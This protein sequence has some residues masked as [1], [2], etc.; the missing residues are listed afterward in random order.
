MDF[1]DFDLD[2][3]ETWLEVLEKCSFRLAKFMNPDSF[4]LVFKGFLEVLASKLFLFKELNPSQNFVIR[5]SNLFEKFK[6]YEDLSFVQ[7]GISSE[8]KQKSVK[9][10]EIRKKLDSYD[11]KKYIKEE[12]NLLLQFLFK[13]NEENLPL[14]M[15]TIHNIIKYISLYTIHKPKPEIF[16]ALIKFLGFCISDSKKIKEKKRSLGEIIKK[17][18][19]KIGIINII[20][21]ILCEK[22]INLQIFSVLI[23]FSYKLLKNG[24]KM[25]QKDFFIY[26]YSVPAS[27]NLFERIHQIILEFIVILSKFSLKNTKNLPNFLKYMKIT[28]KIVKFMQQ[29]CE[30]HNNNLQNYLRFQQ[31]SYKNYDLVDLLIKLLQELMILKDFSTFK[32]I[33]QCFDTL[34]E[35]IQGPC[36]QNQKA[37]IDSKFLE[38][39]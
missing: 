7:P 37:I 8:R 24:N 21:P 15:I 9:T 3:I 22:R 16:K 23:E 18:F 38:I 39:C 5:L 13:N 33:Q 34:T 32:L 17:E 4:Y 12:Q 19:E 26:F 6:I 11:T 28:L 36:I 31:N 2:L 29:L 25:A 35:L 10:N 27:E 30:N 20:L 1:K 14:N